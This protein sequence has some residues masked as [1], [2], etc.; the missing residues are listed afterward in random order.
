MRRRRVARDDDGSGVPG[1]KKKAKSKRKIVEYNGYE[2]YETEKFHLE[3]PIGKMVAK[4][5]VPGRENVKVG[6][7]LYKVLWKGYP[8]ECAT[9]GRRRRASTTSS[10]THLRRS[11]RRRRSWS[12]KSQRGRSQRERG[13]RSELVGSGWICSCHPA[14]P[15]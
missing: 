14:A 2:W 6:T 8:L 3:K 9:C 10:S 11:W 7:V 13:R 5:E 12:K 15:C 1:K 4:G